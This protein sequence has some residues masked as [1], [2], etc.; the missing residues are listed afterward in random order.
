MKRRTPQSDSATTCYATCTDAI[1][2][3]GPNTAVLITEKA[4][5]TPASG[6]VIVVTI[7]IG[8]DATDVDASSASPT[9]NAASSPPSDTTGHRGWVA[10]AVLGSLIGTA[11]VIFLLWRRLRSQ[12][13]PKT[14]NQEAHELQGTAAA[15]VDAQSPTQGHT[16]VEALYRLKSLPKLPRLDC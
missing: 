9:S 1:E 4:M 15:E 8:P 2:A 3:M 11:L 16:L 13:L 12:R 14:E 7:S 6:T 5:P 10:G